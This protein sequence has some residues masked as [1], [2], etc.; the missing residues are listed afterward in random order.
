MEI[1]A[2]VVYFDV[3]FAGSR[4]GVTQYTY[5]VADESDQFRGCPIKKFE[6]FS[7]ND[8]KPH[9]D[10]LFNIGHTQQQGRT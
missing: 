6:I 1:L 9:F 5:L 8:P 7:K 2:V 4:A 3:V 10:I